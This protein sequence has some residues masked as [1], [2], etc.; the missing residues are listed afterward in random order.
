MSVAWSSSDWIGLVQAVAAVATIIAGFRYV[1][2]QREADQ[3]SAGEA[4]GH[5][6]KHSLDFVSE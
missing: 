6:A 4:A 5:L 1:R 2:V 3:D